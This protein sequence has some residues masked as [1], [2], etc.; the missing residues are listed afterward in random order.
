MKS[1]EYWDGYFEDRYKERKEKW[2]SIPL[3]VS[4]KKK[5][6]EMASR[7]EFNLFFF[8]NLSFSVIKKKKKG[9]LEI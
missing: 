1:K 6:L 5:S 8:F 4:K 9:N 2:P 3:K 7:F